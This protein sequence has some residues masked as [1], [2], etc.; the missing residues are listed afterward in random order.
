MN[1]YSTGTLFFYQGNQLLTVKDGAKSRTVLRSADLPLA[2]RHGG[3]GV[4]AALLLASDAQGSPINAKNDQD[5]T[6]YRYTPYGHDPLPCPARQTLLGF[7]GA[8]RNSVHG[9]YLLGNGYRAYSP[10]TMRFNAPDSLS[11]FGK[12]GVNAYAYCTGDPVN[13]SDPTGHFALS[14]FIIT[15]YPDGRIRSPLSLPSKSSETYF[16]IKG[17]SRNGARKTVTTL[18]KT[19]LSYEQPEDIYIPFDML[20]EFRKKQSDHRFLSTYVTHEKP[21]LGKDLGKAIGELGQ[22]LAATM[23]NG[24]K[25]ANRFTLEQIPHPIESSYWIRTPQEPRHSGK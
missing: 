5:G 17:Y 23:D 9:G 13:Q 2:E 10:A 16:R 25:I 11:P 6:S 14:K 7:N 18:V 20:A 4:A 15:T 21:E 22:Y 8:P 24:Q 1:T 19:K 3:I 12:G